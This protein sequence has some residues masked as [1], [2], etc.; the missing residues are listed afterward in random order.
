MR[1][2]SPVRSIERAGDKLAVAVAVDDVGDHHRG[3][4]ALRGEH[5]AAARDRAVGFEVL[6]EA[7]Q[8]A[9]VL[10]LDAEGA[11]DLALG[12]S[13]AAAWRRSARPRRR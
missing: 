9:F 1:G 6:D 10:A 13:R 4:A 5:L 11:G 7:F 3:Q 8:R 12:D 2:A